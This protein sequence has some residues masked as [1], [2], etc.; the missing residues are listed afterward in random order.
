MVELAK[1]NKLDPDKIV[2]IEAEMFQLAF[3]FART[4]ASGL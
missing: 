1:E 3:D 4:S 2:S